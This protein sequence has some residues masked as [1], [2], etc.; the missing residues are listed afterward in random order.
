MNK[1]RWFALTA[2][3]AMIQDLTTCSDRGS[4]PRVLAMDAK[5]HETK[6]FNSFP[7]EISERDVDDC[8]S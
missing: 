2:V 6:N 8:L 4:T 3:V 1:G 7:I 5:N